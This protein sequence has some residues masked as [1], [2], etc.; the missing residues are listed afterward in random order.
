MLARRRADHRVLGVF[1]TGVDG[2][3]SPTSLDIPGTTVLAANDILREHFGQSAPFAVLLRGPAGGDRPPGP[4]A[5]PRPA[6]SDPRGDHALALGPRL[7]RAAAA[8]PAAGAD[9]ARLPRR[10]RRRRSTTRSPSST[11]ILEETIHPPVRA[12]QTGYAT[13][14][15]AIQDESIAAAER[16]ELIALPILLI[17]LLLVFRSPVAAAIPLVFGAVTVVASRGL[18]YDPHQLVRHRRLRAHR[19]HDDGPGARRRLRPADGL[20]LPR[21]ARGRRRRRSTPP[22]SPAAPPGAPRSSPAAPC[23]SRCWSP[24][25]S[26]PARCSPRWPATVALVVV[27]SVLVATS[28]ARRSSPCSGPTSTAGGSGRRPNGERSRLMAVVSAALRRP[29]PVA[30][31]IGAVVLVL[32]APALALK[33]GPP[34]TGQLPKDDPARVDGELI[35]RSVG[36][37]FE[38]PFVVVAATENG[39]ITEPDRLAALSRWQRRIAATARRAGRDRA[40]AGRRARSPRC[41]R[42]GNACSPPTAKAARSPTSAGSAAASA[43]AAG[44]VASSARRASREAAYGAGLLAEGSGRAEDRGDRARPR[45]RPGD[46]RQRTKRS[47][48]LDKFAEGTKRPGRAP[49]S[50]AALGGLVL[51]LGPARTD[52]RTCA[53]TR[54][55]RSRRLQKSLNQEAHDK[56]PRTAG[57]GPGRRRTAEDGARS[58]SKQMTVGKTR[59]QLRGGARRR[60]PGVRRGQRDRPGERPALRRRIR[61]PAGRTGRAAGAAARRRRAKRSRS[62][63]GWSPAVARH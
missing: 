58:S 49:S 6:R 38:S 22:A 4:G 60:A 46:R 41:A 24:S 61:R 59:P 62:P 10:P 17:V 56:L 35:A 39:P 11:A 19:L 25:S 63:P 7:G 31:A 14:S 33:T 45:P 36:A 30:I 57:T 18:L 2:R 47:T 8:E 27:L 54:C 9:P 5:G 15:R 43:R 28:S 48:R 29:S 42:P 40:G 16:S 34:S 44:G 3:L 32:A 21:G 12:T 20:A 13:L 55:G 52:P 23:C 50:R 51:K 37:G 1:G 53:A 26:S